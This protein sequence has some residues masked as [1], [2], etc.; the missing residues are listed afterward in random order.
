MDDVCSPHFLHISALTPNPD[1]LSGIS[2]ATITL[3]L[4]LKLEEHC[5]F[6]SKAGELPLTRN[7][8]DD[9]TLLSLLIHRQGLRPSDSSLIAEDVDNRLVVFQIS[10]IETDLEPKAPKPERIAGPH[11]TRQGGKPSE[12]LPDVRIQ[13]PIDVVSVLEVDGK[14]W[15]YGSLAP[16]GEL[17]TNVLTLLDPVEIEAVGLRL[18]RRVVV[19][20]L[21]EKVRRPRRSDVW[22]SEIAR[23]HG[24]AASHGVFVVGGVEDERDG[25][26]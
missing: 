6:K 24:H 18:L 4:H 13:E 19:L 23:S 21:V 8:S 10:P 9:P 26:W 16:R 25:I 12:N 15:R 7:S 3:V 5:G 22:K 11:G 14:P 2:F 17:T 20:S 1:P